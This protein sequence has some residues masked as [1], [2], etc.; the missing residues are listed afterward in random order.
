MA[1]LLTSVLD[2]TNKLSAYIAEC[3]RLG[4]HVLPPHVNL[5][6][7]GFTVDGKDI[8]F[9]LLA[10]RNLGKGFISGLLQE[11]D[12]GGPFTSFYNFCKRMYGKDLN[13]RALE[14]LVKCGALDNLGYNRRQMLENVASVLESLE[15]D[16]W[17]GSSAFSTV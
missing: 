12:Q 6:R 10:I 16:M 3:I 14:S 11:R 8:R 2:M 4:I 7:N 1:A 9:G 17:M 13:R 15:A 5:S